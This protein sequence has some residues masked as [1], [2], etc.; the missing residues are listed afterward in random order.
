MPVFPSNNSSPFRKILV[1]A[2]LVSAGLAVGLVISSGLLRLPSSWEWASGASFG[3]RRAAIPAFK[4]SF[5]DISRSATAAVVNISAIRIVNARGE[6]PH[7]FPE[8]PRFHHFFDDSIDEMDQRPHR[9]RNLGSGV[10]VDSSGIIVTNDHVVARAREIKVQL[11]DKRAFA[12]RI[13]G[14]DPRTDLAVIKIDADRLPTIP[15][16]DS[17]RLQI[18]E[19]VIAVGNPFGFSESVTMGIVSALGRTN[20]GV[21]DFENFIQTDAAINPGNSGGALV[22]SDG[23]LIGIN[24]AIFSESGGYAGVGFAIPSNMVKRVVSGLTQTGKVVRGWI[25]VTIQDLNAALAEQFDR[26]DLNGALVSDV[27][28]HS[29]AANAGI[30]RGDIIAKVDGKPVTNARELRNAVAEL[31][32]G[33]TVDLDVVRASR[34]VAL[35][36]RI[37]ETPVDSPALAGLRE[38]GGSPREPT[39][40]SGVRVHELSAE[41]RRRLGLPSVA[42]GVVVLDVE[43]GSRAAVS[44]IAAGDVI[45]E[46]NHEPV[47]GVDSYNM[48]ASRL[49]KETSVLLLII[50]E[51]RPLYAVLSP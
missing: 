7:G 41:F 20:V 39:L 25:G 23:Q 15:W 32:V 3:I 8:G 50:R 1:S 6:N 10:I 24:T 11:K 12:A 36:I 37:A 42:P 49:R 47:H 48:S 43:P 2:G 28:P 40:L 22:S 18:G 14:A 51:G 9:E 4:Q 5:V 38:R 27:S 35:R 13:I 34:R 26:P 30:R 19:Y 16:G 45:Q 46:I 21:A 29:P 31:P 33:R 17:D 44:G